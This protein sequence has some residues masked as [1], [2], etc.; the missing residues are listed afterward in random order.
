MDYVNQFG[1]SFSL[2]EDSSSLA[3]SAMDEGIRAIA[4]LEIKRITM[5]LT[6]EL[7][8]YYKL[9]FLSGLIKINFLSLFDAVTLRSAFARKRTLKNLSFNRIL[10]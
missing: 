1:L 10:K 4:S 7:F 3:V 6:L 9:E 2:S 8:A 5:L